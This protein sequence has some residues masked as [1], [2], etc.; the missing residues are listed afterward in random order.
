MATD[1][2]TVDTVFLRRYYVLFVIELERRVV[3]LLGATA[4]PKGP[5]VAQ[6][7]RNFASDLQRLRPTLAFPYPRSRRQVRRHLSREKRES[8]AVVLSRRLQQSWRRGSTQP[9]T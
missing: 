2:F 5:W 7:A 1:F 8:A 6:V 3:H 9:G 4:N